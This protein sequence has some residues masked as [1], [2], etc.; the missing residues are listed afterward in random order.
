MGAAKRHPIEPPRAPGYWRIVAEFRAVHDREPTNEEV[1][2]RLR[3][4]ELLAKRE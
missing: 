2:I 4:R 1:R 3:M